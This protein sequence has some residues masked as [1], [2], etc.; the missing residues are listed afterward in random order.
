MPAVPPSEPRCPRCG[1][2]FDVAAVGKGV[3]S[4]CSARFAYSASSD[5]TAAVTHWPEDDR[6]AAQLANDLLAPGR[7]FG[8][9]RLVKQLGRGAFGAVWEAEHSETG[10]R[11]ALK[12]FTAMRAASPDAFARFQR[13]GRLAASLN[14]PHC[15]FV[16]GAE[17]IDGYPIVSMELM[18]GGTLQQEIDAHGRIQPKRAVDQ[19]LDVIEGLDAA[20][21]VGIIHRDV[22]PSNCFIDADGAVKIGDFGIS[23][24]LESEEAF[25]QTGGFLGT[26]VY[27]SP[28]QV[29]GRDVDLRS[30][31]Y[32]LGATLYAMLNGTPPFAGG[33]AGQV[34]ARVLSE[35][36][37]DINAGGAAVPQALARIVRR[38]MATDR[39]KRYQDYASLRIALLPF[40]SRAGGPALLATRLAAYVADM[41]IIWMPNALMLGF[42]GFGLQA[43]SSA[44]ELLPYLVNVSVLY[45]GLAE[46]Y[47]GQSPG[48]RLFRLRVAT[49][50]GVPPSLAQAFGRVLI[51]T[52]FRAVP[53][54]VLEGLRITPSPFPALV[55]LAFMFLPC[56]TMRRGNGF[57]G[58]HELLTRTRVLAAPQIETVAV[59]VGADDGVAN[60]GGLALIGPY[61]PARTLWSTGGRQLLVGVDE[62]LQR[63]VWIHTFA[64]S[65]PLRTPVI[66]A[67]ARPQ[68]LHW[69]T[70]SRNGRG[71]WDAYEAPSGTSLAGWVTQRGKLSWHELQPILIGLA[72]ELAAGEAEAPN[73]PLALSI[74][75][76]WVDR[77]GQVKLLDFPAAPCAPAFLLESAPD[78]LFHVSV[79]VLEGRLVPA[80]Q[81]GSEPPRL[82]MPDRSHALMQ[83]LARRAP[84][85]ALRA[86]LHSIAAQPTV[87]TRARR[88]GPLFAASLVPLMFAVVP[89][90]VT[91]RMWAM[92]GSAY[93]QLIDSSIELRRLRADQRRGVAVSSDLIAARERIV[94]A[95]YARI[96]GSPMVAR[97]NPTRI[98][99]YEAALQRYPA[100][101]R[102][103]LETAQQLVRTAPS[104]RSTDTLAFALDQITI[105]SRLIAIASVVAMLLT[106]AFRGPVFR[107]SG[108]TLQRRD[109]SRA[110]RASYLARAAIVWAPFLMFLPTRFNVSWLASD[111]SWAASAAWPWA[112]AVPWLLG[113]A[114]IAVA[115]ARPSRGIPDVIA[116]TYLVPR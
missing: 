69:L 102:T 85:P 73:A 34:L 109:G 20:H 32:S 114:G 26:P 95:A 112:L 6:A 108:I 98:Q 31:I 52:A 42:V 64:D 24:T 30:D 39:A 53:Q 43:R 19:M 86:E 29:R 8:A 65:V 48:K 21:T 5:A 70:G 110:G 105:I 101:G 61:R 88:L 63:S 97:M 111:P 27:A 80:S 59:P 1:A 77:Y 90:G 96:K 25:T 51:L 93:G 74:E 71:G 83:S 81:L 79:F 113:L 23:K 103:E 58:V 104:T 89:M 49:A 78:F 68:R 100:V 13:E 44:W 66:H 47:W 33:D 46:W 36:P 17:E 106:W 4:V 56:V 10:R 37:A 76:V 87:V 22:K 60:E 16:F 54:L 7:T 3:C 99:D 82:P 72:D 107:L 18:P 67:A 41:L 91:V 55:D 38:M 2:A 35:E 84:L 75:H 14:H 94:A 116:G 40:S 50:Q 9:Y 45:F 115:L 12:V 28:E 62:T 57:A 92:S 15:V 11:L